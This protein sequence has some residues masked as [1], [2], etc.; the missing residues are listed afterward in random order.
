[1]QGSFSPFGIEGEWEKA[2]AGKAE[3]CSLKYKRTGASRSKCDASAG[4]LPPGH[5]FLCDGFRWAGALRP[6]PPTSW[7]S[8]AQTQDGALVAQ[9]D[10]ADVGDV[11]TTPVAAADH[12]AVVVSNSLARTPHS[13]GLWS[14]F[15]I[16]H[17][18][19]L[20]FKQLLPDLEFGPASRG[21]RRSRRG[22]HQRFLR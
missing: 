2:Q 16:I 13:V 21:G 3:G 20:Q 7:H 1:M 22:R 4:S 15:M 10:V 17:R 6:I 11:C 18:I 19:L 12:V 8:L 9:G 14:P 5:F